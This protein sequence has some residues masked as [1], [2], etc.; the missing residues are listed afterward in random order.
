MQSENQAEVIS[1]EDISI[2]K[3]FDG[4]YANF[5]GTDKKQNQHQFSL[6]FAEKQWRP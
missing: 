6:W 2:A 3:V 4:F 1:S 5:F